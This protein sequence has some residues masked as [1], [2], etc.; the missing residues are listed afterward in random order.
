MKSRVLLFA[1]L[2][3]LLGYG[4]SKAEHIVG[5]EIYWECLSSGPD[6]GKFVFYVKLYRD[7]SVQNTTISLAGHDLLIQNHPDFEGVSIDLD[8]VSEQDISDACGVS[9]ATADMS[10]VSIREYLFASNPIT[11][12][13]VPPPNGWDI[14][15]HRCCRNSLDNILNASNEEVYFSATIYPYDGRDLNPCYDS[16]PQFAEVPVPVVCSG[17]LVRYNAMAFDADFDSLSYSFTSILGQGGNNAIYESGYSF[18]EPLPGPAIDPNYDS[19]TINASNGLL[20]YE[21]PADIQG[22]WAV[23]IEVDAW[24]CGQQVASTMRDMSFTILPCVDTNNLPVVMEPIWLSPALGDGYEVT[25]SAGDLVSFT[26]DGFDYD[27][28]DGQPQELTLSA[29]GQQFGAGFTDSNNGCL[30][31]PCATLSNPPPVTVGDSATL[32]TTF[33]WQT[34]CSHLLLNDDCALESATYQ[35]VFNYTDDFCPINGV[36]PVIVAVTVVAEPIVKS[37]NA[38]CIDVDTYGDVTLEWEPSIDTNS[39]PSFVEYV[40]QHSTS[41]TGPYSTIGAVS[42]IL[43]DEFVHQIANPIQS[44]NLIGPN[45]YRIRTRSGCDDAVLSEADPT[46]ASIFLELTNNTTQ[47]VLNWN[48][49]T[50]P[51][52]STTSQSY[53]VYREYPAGVWDLIGSTPLLTYSDSV[54]WSGEQVNYQV[55]LSDNLP[56][57][58]TSNIVG[59]ILDGIGDLNWTNEIEFFPNP[60]S[61][62]VTVLSETALISGYALLDVSGRIVQKDELQVYQKKLELNLSVQ[63]GTYLLLV[64]TD[65]GQAVQRIIISE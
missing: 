30:N 24:R 12:S 13:G 36:K 65:K 22:K 35:F 57:T 3:C 43:E 6:V 58:S 48:A 56:C 21:A 4:S 55:E 37:P 63:N 45:Y 50:T 38:R 61:S 31:A 16:S 27:L 51:L 2:F 54:V 19:V 49:V 9:C 8:F 15:Y 60:S 10:D 46:V 44:P 20:E 62:K 28:T 42:D 26:L 53:D 41:S 39:I 52:Q 33:N 32:S 47:A 59:D 29:L 18:T 14:V 7:C 40:I 5:G 34:S 25:V 11:I 1:L 17:G 23:A 64:V